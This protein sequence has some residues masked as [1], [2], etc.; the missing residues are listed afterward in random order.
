MGVARMV[1]YKN[2]AHIW[3]D[4]V[5]W[6]GNGDYV[7]KKTLQ[8]GRHVESATERSFGVAEPSD[9]ANI[10]AYTGDRGVNWQVLC[11]GGQTWEKLLI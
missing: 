7:R 6:E 9:E 2:L 5:W 1:S 3:F 10:A 4:V 11:R 8:G